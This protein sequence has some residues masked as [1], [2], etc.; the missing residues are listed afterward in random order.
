[1]FLKQTAR[2]KIYRATNEF[3]EGY[4]PTDTLITA[5]NCDLL[6]ESHSIL[7]RW[8]NYLST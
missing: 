2:T 5:D 6:A 3:K 7:N 1:M 8:N 4:Q